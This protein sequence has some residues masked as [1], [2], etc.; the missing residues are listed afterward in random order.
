M[1]TSVRSETPRLVDIRSLSNESV[2]VSREVSV[3]SSRAP[4]PS[5]VPSTLNEHA[6]A[7]VSKSTTPV[8]APTIQLYRWNSRMSDVSWR[9][10]T[11]S[12]H[13]A[14]H[15]AQDLSLLESNRESMKALSEFLRT[16]DPPPNNLMSIPSD[17]DK[18]LGS[19][20]RSTFRLFGRQKKKKIKLQ[21]FIQLP[22]S[23]VAAR[24]RG[25]ARHI[26]ISIPIE[27]DHLEKGESQF[28][29]P[30]RSH[31]PPK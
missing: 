13:Q 27:H 6:Q 16:K 21:R 9:Q 15:S 29:A 8:P 26:A 5:H 23:A 30:F 3:V 24:T 12:S 22:D 7:E 25:G 20:K 17:D 19:V 10:Q 18:S 4:T 28:L 31:P 14:H 2:H 11:R 1:Q